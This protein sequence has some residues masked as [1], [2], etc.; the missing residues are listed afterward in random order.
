MLKTDLSLDY[1]TAEEFINGHDQEMFVAIISM[2]GGGTS[3]TH[4]HRM[5]ISDKQITIAGQGPITV[6]AGSSGAIDTITIPTGW[7]ITWSISTRA[8]LSNLVDFQPGIKFFND[9][10]TKHSHKNFVKM[11]FGSSATWSNQQGSFV[12]G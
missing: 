9:G 11:N 6:T 3:K 8:P 2:E 10:T 1:W 4:E 7:T 5:F 12:D